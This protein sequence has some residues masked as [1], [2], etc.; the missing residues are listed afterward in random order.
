MNRR[1]PNCRVLIPIDKGFYF[2]KKQ[3]MICAV[4]NKPIFVVSDLLETTNIRKFNCDYDYASLV[5]GLP[6][7]GIP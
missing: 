4:C 3:N 6:R 2:D 7:W 5:N 1:C